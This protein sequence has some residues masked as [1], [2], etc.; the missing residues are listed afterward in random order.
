MIS[1]L[2]S[3]L[4]A[5]QPLLVER[6]ST[7]RI[8]LRQG[9]FTFVGYRDRVDGREHVAAV[10]GRLE[11]DSS[12]LLRVH[13]ECLTGDVFGSL[14]CDCGQQLKESLTM[15][16]ENGSGVVVYLRGHEGRG[17]GLLEKLSAYQL[18]DRGLDTVE[19]NRA[20]GHAADARD[21]GIGAAILADLDIRAVRL[22]TNNP[23][24]RTA[25]VRHGIE[26]V[27]TVVVATDPTDENVR[28][29]RTK[30]AKLGHE[31]D[32]GGVAGQAH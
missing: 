7:A 19:A 17:I 20:L 11:A 29:L 4:L 8:P 30:N 16:A 9:V 18:Q 5:A 31:L 22:I 26:V 2:K 21:Y 32:L 3:Y 13:S 28:Y 24:K 14:R 12:V 6:V 15:V 1:D 27:E 25:L 10:F 23:E